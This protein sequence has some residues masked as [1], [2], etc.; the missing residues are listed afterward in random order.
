LGHKGRIKDNPGWEIIEF[1]DG[2]KS[3]EGNLEA[4]K[5]RAEAKVR[6][7]KEESQSSHANQ[8]HDQPEL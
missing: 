3:H 2:F 1:L 6:S 5:A 4:N 7:I 8:A